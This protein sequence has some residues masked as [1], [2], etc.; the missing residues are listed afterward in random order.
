[1]DKAK[2]RKVEKAAIDAV[3]QEGIDFYITIDRPGLLRRLLRRTSHYFIIRPLFL[4][5]LLRISRIMADMKLP[6][7]IKR[8]DWMDSG[9]DLMANETEHLLDIVSLAIH[10]REGTPDK[11]IKKLLRNN[12]TPV[13][14]LALVSYVINQMNVQDFMKSIISVKGMSLINDGGQIARQPEKEVRSGA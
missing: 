14:L 13:E 12:V 7:Q 2:E 4:G 3:L 11:K 5:T 10:N 1:M 6:E 9:I 8:A